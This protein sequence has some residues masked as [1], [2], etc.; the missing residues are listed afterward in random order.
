MAHAPGVAFA[1]QGC[2]QRQGRLHQVPFRQEPPVGS[3][4]IDIIKAI[5]ELDHLTTPAA[6]EG[7]QPGLRVSRII[8]IGNPPHIIEGG[9]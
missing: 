9:S 4:I 8:R 7:G 1:A 3:S 6:F 5:E 2:A